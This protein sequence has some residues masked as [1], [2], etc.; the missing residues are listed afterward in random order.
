MK[1][2]ICFWALVA[3]ACGQRGDP[4]FFI[5]S[6]VLQYSLLHVKY[7][8]TIIFNLSENMKTVTCFWALIALAYG[9]CGDP[10]ENT[11][12]PAGSLNYVRRPNNK[13][14]SRKLN[15]KAAFLALM[16]TA[17]LTTV[18]GAFVAQLGTIVT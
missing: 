9:Q 15:S 18:D 3:L 14:E 16:P 12:C 4:I 5:M 11:A 10:S 17:A 13:I 8:I 1:T 2:L 7:W 6:G